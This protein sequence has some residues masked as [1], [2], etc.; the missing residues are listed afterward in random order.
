MAR[1]YSPIFF[2][3]MGTTHLVRSRLAAA[4]LALSL[5]AG[6]GV[7]SGFASSNRAQVSDAASRTAHHGILP[8]VRTS[9]RGITF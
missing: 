9:Q 5:L 6:G 7:G 8:S 1:R 2:D 4:L 3:A